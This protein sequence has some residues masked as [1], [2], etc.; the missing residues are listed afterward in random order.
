[1]N[2][3]L[4]KIYT[5]V[6]QPGFLGAGHTA[7]AVLPLNYTE[8]DPF[9]LL[10]DDVLDKKDDI[11]VGGPHPHAGF[12]TVSLL[13]EG[14]IGDGKHS[15]KAGDFQVMTAGSGIVHTET[16]QKRS[17]MRL[18]QMWLN[19]PRENRWTAPRLQDLPF[20][21]V[22]LYTEEGVD[23][24]VYSGTLKGITSPVLNFV[25]LIVGDVKLKNN[26]L[27]RLDIPANYTAFIY[28]LDGEVRVGET[29]DAISHGQVGWFERGKTS[30]DTELTFS[31]SSRGSRF[32]LY[33]AAPQKEEIISHGPFIGNTQEDIIR[34]YRDYREG[35]MKHVTLLP[36]EQLFVW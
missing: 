17:T 12:E 18:L 22:P 6:S 35:K 20:K 34:L 29:I 7:T 4:K 9:L 2:R 26:T 28:V 25:P 24:R 31:T 15:M 27:T 32:V 10:M 36:E 19:L 14:E 13:L 3:K 5:P 33:A 1:M 16:I 23:I 30:G 11:P 8:T 21:D